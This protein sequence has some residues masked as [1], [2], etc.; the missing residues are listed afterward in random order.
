[1]NLSFLIWSL[2]YSILEHEEQTLFAMFPSY[3][4]LLEVLIYFHVLSRD[5]IVQQKKKFSEF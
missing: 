2:L 1:M 4:G 3:S 5:F